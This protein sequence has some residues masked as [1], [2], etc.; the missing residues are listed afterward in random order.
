MK[1]TSIF[2][3]A[4]MILATAAIATANPFS[5]VPAS[6]WAYDAVNSMAEKGIVQGFPDGTFK[7][8]QN[9]TRYQ[10]AMITAKMIANVEQ[11]GGNGSVSKTDLQTLEKLTV[12][13]ADE[14]ALLGVKVTALEDDMQVV[15]EDVAGLK[16]DVDGIKSY[17]K[18]GGME[19]VRLSG[20]MLVRN[21][22]FT[23]DEVKDQFGAIN[24]PEDHRHTTETMLRLQLDAQID[25]NV[26]ARARWNMIGDLDN[27]AGHSNEWHG[28]NKNTSDVEVAYI[29]IKDMFSFGGDFKFGRDWYQHGHGFVVHNYMDAVNYTKRC[30]DVDVA[31]NVFFDRAN[32]GEDYYNTWNINADYST[33]GHDLYLGFYYNANDRLG[34]SADHDNSMR[35]EFGAS[36]KL[37]NNNEKVKYD[38]GLVYSK[39]ENAK[40]GEVAGT[41][42]D[43]TGIL[44]H[45][46]VKYDDQ[47]QL[48]ARLAYTFADDESNSVINVEN[49]NRYHD[50][51][52]TIFE[53]IYLAQM[54]R[55]IP[56]NNRE[57]FKNLN[58]LK[59]EVCYTLKNND[60]HSFRLAY[61]NISNKDDNKPNTFSMNA[62]NQYN[63]DLKGNLITFEYTY[64]LAE[65]TRLR[66]GYQNS[67]I[68][69][70]TFMGAGNPTYNPGDVKANLYYTEIYSRF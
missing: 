36:G 69:G 62:A 45:V 8:K 63:N 33:K 26:T 13:F 27:N 2:A 15:K 28:N 68:E 66:L 60:K 47:K 22:G 51:D 3:S 7:G 16:K 58:D 35:I 12:E 32:G 67:K 70:N 25:E 14:L 20:D 30:G 34:I 48:K 40:N 42:D 49:S 29:Q 6:H 5:D 17:M 54:A 65:N 43:E 57:S 44:A 55:G 11:M 38:L 39:I 61:D 19:K 1:N 24:R 46:A 10:L 18:N 50:G 21:Y 56:A 52:E 9:V 31:F 59:L 37:S 53:D 64:K 4:A 23:N 41:F